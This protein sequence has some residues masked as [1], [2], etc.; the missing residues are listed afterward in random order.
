VC[1]MR[2]Q[3]HSRGPGS[4]WVSVDHVP[5]VRWLAVIWERVS[6]KWYTTGMLSLF[7]LWACHPGLVLLCYN[8]QGCQPTPP[9]GIKGVTALS[10]QSNTTQSWQYYQAHN[11][12]CRSVNPLP[13]LEAKYLRR[14]CG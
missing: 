8:T 2:I 9:A 12:M 6:S 5:P 13:V 11:T 7:S 14:K 1:N 4:I 10:A 3:A